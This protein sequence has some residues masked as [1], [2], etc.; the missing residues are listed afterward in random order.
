[1]SIKIR[2]SISKLFG[3]LLAT[4][5]L[6]CCSEFGT[7]PKSSIGSHNSFLLSNPENLLSYSGLRC[8]E[9]PDRVHDL[10][11]I[12]NHGVIRTCSLAKHSQ[13]SLEP[14]FIG[15]MVLQSH[16]NAEINKSEGCIWQIKILPVWKLRIQ[17]PPW[18]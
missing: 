2:P 15:A 1:M 14:W 17:P 16:G 7:S 4:F 6:D 5:R 10:T 13:G 8:S 12:L 3:Y 11:G 9:I 18:G